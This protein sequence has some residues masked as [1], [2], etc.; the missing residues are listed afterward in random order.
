M[1][2]LIFVGGA[3]EVGKSAVMRE[4]LTQLDGAVWLDA[5]DV[6]RMHPFIVSDATKSMVERNIQ[7]VLRSFLESGFS[8][9][10]LTWVLHH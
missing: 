5:D 6:W 9:I 3:P 2:K 7:F 4:L 1:R 10:F 8:Y